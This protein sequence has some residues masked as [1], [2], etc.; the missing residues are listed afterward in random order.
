MK[1]FIVLLSLVLSMQIFPQ[2][3]PTE[4]PKI[5]FADMYGLY[6]Y[7]APYWTPG[8]GPYADSSYYYPR[9]LELGLT[10]VVTDADPIPLNPA[11]NNSIKILDDNFAHTS[12][13]KPYLYAQG[14]GNHIDHLPYEVGG[15]N[16]SL[17]NNTGD[18]FG[19]G[20]NTSGA[21]C[22]WWIYPFD[23]NTV[24][25]KAQPDLNNTIMVHSAIVGV[26]NPGVIM[27]AE[28]D[29]THQAYNAKGGP[30]S[31]YKL[32]INA[33]IDGALGTD[34]VAKVRIYEKTGS[35]AQIY[36]NHQAIN[37]PQQAQPTTLLNTT[38]TDITYY[39]TANDFE[40][41]QYVN[42][43]SPQ[44]QKFA[45]IRTDN[46]STLAVTIE[47]LGTRNLYIDK[48]SV[49]NQYYED[50][51]ITNLP[52]AVT[53]ITNDLNSAFSSV[54]N[55]PLFAHL[56]NDEPM[57]LMYRAVGKVSTI[58]EQ[59]LGSGK[60]INGATMDIPLDM[61]LI[62]NNE[63]RAPYVLYDSY[64]IESFVDTVSSGINNIQHAFDALTN[65]SVDIGYGLHRYFGLRQ[66][67]QWAQN[68]TPNDPVDD[69]PLYSCIQV[70][71]EKDI[72]NGTIIN[73]R[74]RAPTPN[75]ILAEGNLSLCYGAKGIMYFTIMTNTPSSNN[76]GTVY[77]VYGLFDD[78]SNPYNDRINPIAGLI[79]NPAH[80]QKVNERF[81][82]VKNLN[83][84]IDKI[85]GDLLQLTWTNGFSIYQGQPTGTFIT[86][87]T[88]SDQPSYTFVELGTFKKSDQMTN[89]NLDYFFV[90][91]RRTLSTEQRS[92]AVTI[93]KSNT[94]YNNWKVTEV[95][96][97]NTWTVSNTGSFTT[98][99]QPGE[100]KLFKME[101]VMVAGGTLAYNENIP[102]TTTINSCVTLTILP[103]VNLSFT[104]GASL[105]INGTLI[106]NGTNVNRIIFNR[107]GPNG[108]WGSLK[109]DGAGASSS[110]LNNV[111]VYNSAN[112]QILNDANIIVENSK[113][114]DCTQSIYVYNA[115]P[116]IICNEIINPNQHGIYINALNKNPLIRD[117]T[118]TKTVGNPNYKHQEGIILYNGTSGYITHNSIR[119]FDH[120]IY[121]GGSNAYFTDYTWQNNFPNN[122]FTENHYGIMVGWG[123]L[124]LGGY[125][126]NICW[127]NS[128]S[129]NDYYNIYVYQ[130]STAWAEY[131]YWGTGNLKQYA[132]GTSTLHALYPLTYDPWEL[133]L[134]AVKTELPDA[135][136][137]TANSNLI[138][139]KEILFNK[140]QKTVSNNSFGPSKDEDE[141]LK[142]IKLEQEGKID[143]AIEQLKKI[144][145]DKKYGVYAI[146]ELGCIKERYGK[147]NV[148]SY[149]EDLIKDP[150]EENKSRIKKHLA[151]FY[152]NK[153]EDDKATSMFDELKN[154]KNS[155]KENF[156]GLLNKFNYTLHKKKDIV[157]AKNL[158]AEIKN[159]FSD[160]EEAMLHIVTA[161]ML[162][163]EDKN[164]A[165]G[166]KQR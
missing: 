144:V 27:R 103:G 77:S 120:G 80:P 87:V 90:V 88:T 104:N 4:F 43:S 34:N 147:E 138:S 143:E 86:Q 152:L 113:I 93:N 154:N 128:I 72:A 56:Y 13:K 162:I 131:N 23:V 50:L 145:K 151:G 134:A 76:T 150:N 124:L 73:Q 95:G 96:T 24:G 8:Q 6:K 82:A 141:F 60:Y 107:S 121:V 18:F 14:V 165:L 1:K 48:I 66:A 10:H 75:E 115:S 125:G 84:Y 65:A 16:I 99:Y 59:T 111:E 58:A 117:N 41:N 164:F 7:P 25:D 11:Y 130:S 42:L 85:K 5:G 39:I 3:S 148:Q 153:N 106:A 32:F 45:D 36:A 17:I 136:V 68:F 40:G 81:Y 63:R 71:A 139:A 21:K 116:Q 2:I 30:V 127:S 108:L 28:P 122:Q 91:N 146:T 44:F 26:D 114:Q 140:N 109:F 37:E 38:L 97:S 35:T 15:S 126:M 78:A 137:S 132:D 22:S 105:T 55:N 94:I 67:I 74:F 64:K 155:K 33:K 129:G 69:K 112:I 47:W 101:P 57:P 142:G 31:Y 70:Q 51:F 161:E 123:S 54:K 110:I 79:Q 49:S 98:S 135:Q 29:Y 157:S 89:A 133:W 46:P 62:A 166:K 92:I 160:D 156:E 119:G 12:Y 118:I 61:M 159:K 102:Q 100:G 20:T 52:S 83:Q 149:F 19:F 163:S 158:L 9:L 53:N